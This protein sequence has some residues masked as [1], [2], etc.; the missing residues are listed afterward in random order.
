M[1]TIEIENIMN[2]Q[3]CGEPV[4]RAEAR[5]AELPP[6]AEEDV[7]DTSLV[8]NAFRSYKAIGITFHHHDG[9]FCDKVLYDLVRVEDE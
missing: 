3:V 7:E 1:K 2:C 8:R 9:T 6:Y 4:S 5:L